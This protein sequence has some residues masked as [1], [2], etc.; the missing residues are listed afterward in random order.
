MDDHAATAVR[1]R[2]DSGGPGDPPGPGPEAPA[3][4]VLTRQ[5]R[6]FTAMCAAAAGVL[7]LLAM[8]AHADH[9]PALGRAFLAVGLAQIVWAVL[10]MVDLRRVVVVA[11]A[12]LTAGAVAV[13][14]FSRSTG[15]SWFP[16]L[17]L[18]EPIEWRDT[19]TQFFQLLALAGAV[20]V[21]LPAAANR[22]AGRRVELVPIA[23]MAALTLGALGVLY[24]GTHDY[25]HHDHQPGSADEGHSH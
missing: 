7:H 8:A 13:W 1:D 9:H 3:E 17:E 18:P 24:A 19:V 15:I 10:L 25:T 4:T 6:Y 12:L 11:G 5:A 23:I 2:D 14:V 16:G 21:L 22:P 20:V